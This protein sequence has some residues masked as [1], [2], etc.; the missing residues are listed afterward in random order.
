MKNTLKYLFAMALAAA[1]MRPAPHGYMMAH[2]SLG[3][4]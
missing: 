3:R 1:G 4:N 2:A